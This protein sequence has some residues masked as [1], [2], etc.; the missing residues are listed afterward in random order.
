MN[1]DDQPKIRATIEEMMTPRFIESVKIADV[2]MTF[3]TSPEWNPQI[4]YGT[5]TLQ[6]VTSS[7]P[8]TRA[9]GLYLLIDWTTKEPEYLTA[10]LLQIKG[11]CDLPMSE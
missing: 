10:L 5:Q 9:G 11:E 1:L 8:A 2:I 6:R 4:A 3:P 7:G